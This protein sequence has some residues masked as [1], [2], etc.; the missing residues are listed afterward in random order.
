MRSKRKQRQAKKNRV[1][2]AIL[3]AVVIIAAIFGWL[4]YQAKSEKIVLDPE[5][6]CPL[7][8]RYPVTAILIDTTDSLSRDQ[9][10]YVN[11][12]ITQYI[13]NAQKYE[14]LSLY[15]L[16][17]NPAEISANLS[18]CNPGDGSDANQLTSN[19]KMI[20]DRW[21]E[22]FMSRLASQLLTLETVEE[23]EMSPILEGMKFVSTDAFVGL[24]ASQKKLFVVSDLLQYSP[25][26]SHYNNRYD[27]SD[28]YFVREVDN[29]LPHLQGVSVELFYV[30]RPNYRGNQTNKHIMFWEKVV[31]RSGGILSQIHMVK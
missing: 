21:E 5:S 18:I 26:I 15:F 2:Y 13:R 25:V 1:G 19:T 8:G 11:R 3:F 9:A 22:Q 27:I 7:T 30:T 14:K 4:F 29:L 17:E 16:N 23:G 10:L 24:E 6:N 20:R 31:N 12:V 28:D